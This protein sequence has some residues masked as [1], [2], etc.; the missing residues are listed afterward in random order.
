LKSTYFDE[1][2]A[3][4]LICEFPRRAA[5]GLF[6]SCLDSD[7]SE[8]QY[9]SIVE[10]L[11]MNPR[12][13]SFY[14]YLIDDE[15]HGKTGKKR[16]FTS[17]ELYFKFQEAGS[18]PGLKC[19]PF[20]E[21]KITGWHPY[22]VFLDDIQEKE[23]SKRY[24][25]KYENI[26]NQRIIPA[27]GEKG[28]LFITGTIKGWDEETDVYIKL[29]RTPRYMVHQYP[30]VVD[31]ETG[32]ASF[33][34][35]SDVEYEEVKIPIL[36][37]KGNQVVLPSGRKIY[38]KDIKI[39]SI[40]DRGRYKLNFPKIY[41]LESLIKIR[42]E[43]NNDD[44]FFSEYQLQASDPKGK[45]FLKER[46]RPMVKLNGFE[47][48]HDVDSF[49]T[50]TKKFHKRPV[51]WVD[52]GGESGHGMSIIVMCK[53]RGCWFL[54]D[55]VVVKTGIPDTVKEIARLLEKWNLKYWD[56]EGNFTQKEF[57][58]KTIKRDLRKY[59][60]A[61]KKS[62]KYRPPVIRN[63]TG[64]KIQ[65]IREGFSSMLGIDGMDYTFY[66]NPSMIALDRFNK[67]VREFGL[68]VDT[69]RK[70]HEYDL[71]DAIVSADVHLLRD[72][73]GKRGATCSGLK[74]RKNLI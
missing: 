14:G 35:M 19:V 26:F 16:K 18:R 31:V 44:K 70:A 46:I 15:K 37:S 72:T 32:E 25:A 2:R 59:L 48:F 64:N 20:L 66:Y 6:I 17:G 68:D 23:L 57:V 51:L 21:I 71:L 7:L 74:Y 67:E 28:L 22:A 38:E 41:T 43:M 5:Q 11:S 69:T 9:N 30:A 24:R 27:V 39:I 56:I 13:L 29:M 10:N 1:G 58:G 55:C 53:D 33:P 52:R 62:K 40:K 3:A 54:L 73:H 63:N 8:A 42:I 34:P 36:D 45:Y 60:N 49:I 12:L 50:Y 47:H 61:Q 4:Y 65:R